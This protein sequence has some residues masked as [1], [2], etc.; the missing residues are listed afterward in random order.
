MAKTELKLVLTGELLDEDS[1]ITL[2]ELCRTCDVKAETIEALV[3]QGILEPSDR[4]GALWRFRADSIKRT[5]IVLRLQ[6]DL[7][8]NLAGAA[9]ALELLERIEELSARLRQVRSL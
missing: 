1:E 9:L 4:P 3:E 8:V 5:R 6:R 7:G 2:L